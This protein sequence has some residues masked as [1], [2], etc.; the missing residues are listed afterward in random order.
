MAKPTVTI[1]EKIRNAHLWICLAEAIFFACKMIQEWK[2]AAGHVQTPGFL[3][4]ASN[5]SFDMAVGIVHG[6]VGS[7]EKADLQLEPLLVELIGDGSGATELADDVSLLE[8]Q[9]TA[10]YPNLAVSPSMFTTGEGK[11]PGD[12]L[13]SL[14]RTHLVTAGLADLAEIKKDFEAGNFHK[15]RHQTIAHKNPAV[16]YPAGSVEMLMYPK[17]MATFGE[18]IK[19]LRIK[20]YL[21]FNWSPENPFMDPVLKD[22]KRILDCEKT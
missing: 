12:V 9:I 19:K 14:K 6:L 13:K 18:V 5:N 15:L 16:L 10:M 3:V 20:A 7:T 11:W 17:V 21:W 2:D 4:L 1:D 22:L 8:S